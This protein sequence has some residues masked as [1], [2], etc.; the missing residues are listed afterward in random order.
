MNTILE[1]FWWKV[2]FLVLLINLVL[3][4]GLTAILVQSAPERIEIARE[5]VPSQLRPVQNYTP[6]SE[7]QTDLAD[8]LNKQNLQTAECNSDS[9]NIKPDFSRPDNNNDVD[10]VAVEQKF[11]RGGLFA[12]SKSNLQLYAKAGEIYIYGEKYINPATVNLI[13]CTIEHTDQVNRQIFGKYAYK[14]RDLKKLPTRIIL[15]DSYENYQKV[16]EATYLQDKVGNAPYALSEGDTISTYLFNSTKNE[17]SNY[18]VNSVKNSLVMN[19]AHE[20]THRLIHESG[21]DF[22]PFYEEGMATYLGG[23]VAGKVV[24]GKFDCSFRLMQA[25]YLGSVSDLKLSDFMNYS[26]DEWLYDTVNNQSRKYSS[27]YYFFRY[28][29][30]KNDL[31]QYLNQLYSESTPTIDMSD[32]MN[33]AIDAQASDKKSCIK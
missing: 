1:Q 5:V 21:A 22:K 7:Y 14:I 16:F 25:N 10:K 32:F 11:S 23:E 29:I 31:E 30:Q 17:D 8:L 27:A 19:I 4:A 18:I 3:V 6:A 13:L 12:S 20:Y 33:F 9:L 15:Y 24:G 2:L 28:H 26:S